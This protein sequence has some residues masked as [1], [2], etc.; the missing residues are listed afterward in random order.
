M[1][2]Q[3]TPCNYT[4]K[5]LATAISGIQACKNGLQGLSAT[6]IGIVRFTG[7][8]VARRDEGRGVASVA[9]T[10]VGGD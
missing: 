9:A 5:P 7:A 8:G 6:Y 10:V 1:Q 4:S 2:P 3:S